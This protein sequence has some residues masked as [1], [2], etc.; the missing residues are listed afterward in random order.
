MMDDYRAYGFRVFN[1]LFRFIGL[2]EVNER[3]EDIGPGWGQ[4][5]LKTEVLD[6]MFEFP[7]LRIV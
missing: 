6:M 1:C 3:D 7:M 4:K 2:C 5:V